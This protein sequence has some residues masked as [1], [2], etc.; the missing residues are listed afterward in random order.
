MPLG[1]MISGLLEPSD[2]KSVPEESTTEAR[3]TR[4]L[5]ILALLLAFPSTG[6]VQK[7]AGLGGVAAYVAVVVGVVFLSARLTRRF[8]PWLKCRF[9][10]LS[11]IS[12]VALLSGFVLLHPF[13]DGRGPGKSS[14]R[15]EGLEMAVSRLAN[16][17]TPYYPSNKVAGPL[18]VMPG[19]ILLAAPF[20]ALGNSGYQNVFWLAAFL[21]AGRS[22]F[23]DKVA[24]LWLLVIPLA[25]S[26]AAQY[27]FVS[28]GDLIANGIFVALLF[29][30]TLNAWSD[31][32]APAWQRWLCCLLV[33][34]G[35]ASRANFILLLPLFG[36]AMWRVAGF[37]SALLV[38]SLAGLVTLSL[39]VPFY[40]HDPAGFAPLGSSNKLKYWDHILPFASRTIVGSTVLASLLGAV[41]LLL[42]CTRNSIAAFFRCCTIVT[43]V[44]MVGAVMVASWVNGHPDFGIMKD[45]FGLMFIYFSL[46]GWGHGLHLYFRE[47]DEAE[48]QDNYRDNP[49][50]AR[51]AGTS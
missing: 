35:L 26:M 8:A 27:E 45:R 6:F 16:G 33:G 7:Y 42:R 43:L 40:L 51:H 24:A 37:K 18:S 46:L 32:N 10:E 22:F 13:E 14:D 50:I 4:D 1:L 39:T 23:R 28:G 19:S 12:V 17:E 11:I 36:A 25:V 30:W 38:T 47:N 44:P 49:K 3:P 29:L 2:M 21:I 9:R 41:W 48:A 31:S 34:V 15:D 20:V 5:W